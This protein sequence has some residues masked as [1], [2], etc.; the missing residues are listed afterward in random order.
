[1]SQPYPVPQPVPAALQPLPPRPPRVT[2]A[3]VP[4]SRL[5]AL[6]AQR[7]T[8]MA[9]AKEAQDQADAINDG[10][11]AELTAIAPQGTKV[12]DIPAGPMWPA[13]RLSWERPWRVDAPRLK[14]EDPYTYVRWAVQSDGYWKLQ[15]P[16]GGS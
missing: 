3:P 13:L 14:R 11:K 10:I 1:M 16:R 8:A 15:A 4:G 7:E 2:I 9:R 12:I 6:L 5:E